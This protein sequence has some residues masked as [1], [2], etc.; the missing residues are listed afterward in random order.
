VQFWDE[1]QTNTDSQMAL[2]CRMRKNLSRVYIR[3]VI[4]L[5]N[6]LRVRYERLLYDRPGVHNRAWCCSTG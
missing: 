6:S 5:Q 2:H 3:A 1:M 4:G